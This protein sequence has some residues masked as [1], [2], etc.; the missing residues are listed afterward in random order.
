[1]A[2]LRLKRV[3]AETGLSKST[4]YGM[5]KKGEFPAPVRLSDKAVGWVDLE[6]Q[7]WGEARIKASRE[8]LS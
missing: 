4:L 6:I 3:L 8:V 1:M 7:Y 2:F 5:V